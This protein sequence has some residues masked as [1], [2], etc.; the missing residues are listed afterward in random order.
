MYNKLCISSVIKIPLLIF[1]ANILKSLDDQLT[2]QV[3]I[4]YRD[5]ALILLDDTVDSFPLP[6]S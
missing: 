3:N 5:T 1:I 4:I 6:V 2:T